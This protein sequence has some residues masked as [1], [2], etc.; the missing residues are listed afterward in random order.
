MRALL[1]P[2]GPALYGLPLATLA[3]VLGC[4]HWYPVLFA[5]RGLCGLLDWPG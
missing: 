5:V 1:E 3:R 4:A 2:V